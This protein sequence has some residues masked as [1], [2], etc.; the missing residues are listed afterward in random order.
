MGPSNSKEFFKKS[1]DLESY[2]KVV[3]YETDKKSDVE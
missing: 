2:S 3:D 1:R